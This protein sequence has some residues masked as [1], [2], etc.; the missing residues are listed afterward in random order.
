LPAADTT[1]QKDG[2]L[3]VAI[4][5]MVVRVIRK[6]TGRGPTK[7]RAHVSDELIA[8]VLQ[9]TLSTAERTLIANGQTEVLY[10]TRRAFRDTMRPDLV[11]GVEQLTGRTVTAFFCDHSFEPDIV[12]ES[13]LLAPRDVASMQLSKRPAARTPAAG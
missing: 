1:V 4:S 6:H 2:Q 12:L 8:V 13:F 9:D 7:S 11:A 5:T 10:A 3:A